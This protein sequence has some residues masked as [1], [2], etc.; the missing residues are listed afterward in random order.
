M[1]PVD[2]IDPKRL[3]LLIAEARELGPGDFAGRGFHKDVQ[4][5]AAFGIRR[6]SGV[7]VFQDRVSELPNRINKS[8]LECGSFTVHALGL[9]VD[10][11][12][13]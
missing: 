12:Q 8:K 1:G 13:T 2:H 7:V 11:G 6:D 9:R 3:R 5:V 4:V 10:Y